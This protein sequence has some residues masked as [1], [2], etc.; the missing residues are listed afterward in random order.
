MVKDAE[1]YTWFGLPIYESE[2]DSKPV[3]QD[4]MLKFCEKY[5]EENKHLRG[6]NGAIT[7]DTHGTFSNIC[8]TSSDFY[9]LSH[10]VGLHATTYLGQLGVDTKKVR[11]NIVK[12]WPVCCENGSYIK[13]HRHIGSHLS[14]VYYV[15]KETDSDTGQLRFHRGDDFMRNLPIHGDSMFSETRLSNNYVDYNLGS[16]TI[17]IF[18]STVEHEVTRYEGTSMRYSISLDILVTAKTEISN[19][20]HVCT[21]PST[22]VTI[23]FA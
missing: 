22:W 4:R 17:V 21:D 13:P 15:Q 2:V 6:G 16:N 9:Y 8:K 1:I 12:S 19:V 3:F 7:G 5:Y 18:P 20:E 10:A 23:P 14:A 11:L